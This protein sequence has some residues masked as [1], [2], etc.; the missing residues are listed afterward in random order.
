MSHITHIRIDGLMGRQEPLILD[1]DRNVNVFFGENGCGKTTLLKILDSALSIESGAA[2]G[3]PFRR[4]EIH[5]YSINE[6]TTFKHVWDQSGA[7]EDRRKKNAIYLRERQ[8]SIFESIG[9]LEGVAPR[10]FME[11]YQ[12]LNASEVW[13]IS[14]KSKSKTRRWAHTFLPTNRLF[15]G[16]IIQRS[17]RVQLSDA[18]LDKVFAESVSSAWL[19]FY[20][21]TL[22]NVRDIQESG[23]TK[24]LEGML[25]SDSELK[26]DQ[27]Q[28]ETSVAYQKVSN[29]LAR[30][31][32]KIRIGSTAKF[33]ERYRTSRD[34]QR[35]VANI[36]ETERAIE[37]AVAPVERFLSTITNLLSR[38][39][40]L[41]LD[42]SALQ[43]ALENGDVL[44]LSGLSSG[45]KH[46]VKILLSVISAGPNSVIIDEPELSLHIDWQRAFVRTLQAINPTCQLILAS[47]S[48]EVMADVSDCCIFKL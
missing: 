41:Q 3:L 1:L 31:G 29:F 11:A 7:P 18:E 4:A 48:P 19:Q 25:A 34:L 38:G 21:T 43:I 20:S 27:S 13:K 5:I 45:E 17:S 30:Q 36:D 47:H 23:L 37:K 9:D 26:S 42:G 6:D 35:V 10:A 32:R 39:K 15:S 22:S 44:P 28:I 2:S 33:N 14:P 12:R 16:E 24:I 40:K 46:L 8:Q